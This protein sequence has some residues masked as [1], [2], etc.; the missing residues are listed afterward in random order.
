MPSNYLKPF[1]PSVR[2]AASALVAAVTM[3]TAQAAW[4]ETPVGEV[5]YLCC[6]MRAGNDWISDINYDEEGMRVLPFGTPAKVLSVSSNRILVEI[7]GKTYKFNNDYSR[8]LGMP[9]FIRRYLLPVD[10][11]PALKELPDGARQAIESFSVVPGMTREQ[12]LL[13]IAYPIADETPDLSSD[14]WKY[15]RDS[16]HQ[17]D[18]KFDAHGRVSDITISDDDNNNRVDEKCVVNVYRPDRKFGDDSTHTY[19]QVDDKMIGRLRTSDT[20]CLKLA[21]GKHLIEV[22]NEYLFMPAAVVASMEVMVPASDAAQFLRFHRTLT[23]ASYLLPGILIS[24]LLSDNKM[25]L[26]D[27]ESWRKRK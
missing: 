10:P 3:A 26:V 20:Y 7:E 27:E 17:Y 23:V 22:R 12:V 21:P 2:A 15:W 18:L 6:N 25:T 1:I 4:A 8:K 13:A 19:L 5:R 11:R 24:P 14:V 16:S 9:E